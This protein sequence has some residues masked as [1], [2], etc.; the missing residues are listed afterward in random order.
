MP[1]IRIRHRQGNFSLETEFS[2]S[3]QW[4]V[5]FGPSGAGKSTLLRILAGLVKPES[6]RIEINGR[7]L[8]DTVHGVSV[9]VG[10]R[11]LGFVTQQPALFPHLTVRDNVS[12]GLG[13]VSRKLRSPRV[14]EVL[15]LFGAEALAD[16]PA[17]QLS[18]GE[19][20]RVA[21]ARA[22][23]PRPDLLLLDE[24][25]T[26]LDDAS[27]HDILTRLLSLNL[28]VVYISH[29]IAETWR[30]PA[31]VV[32]LNAGRVTAV[33]PLREVLAAH[34]ERLLERLGP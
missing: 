29:D 20:Q 15:H 25:L 31:Q 2:L 26:G 7:T 33:G 6:G 28:R 8:L 13:H 12:F 18:G 1:D 14:T 10:S 3:N 11:S 23:A 24:P 17:S 30:I 21:L 22:L 16:Q 27:A 32:V 34:R 19:R 5:V 4:T 9:P